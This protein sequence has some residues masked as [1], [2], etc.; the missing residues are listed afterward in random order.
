[1]ENETVQFQNHT[2]F[3]G[4]LVRE[5]GKFLLIVFLLAGCSTAPHVSGNPGSGTET[6]LAA[7]PGQAQPAITASNGPFTLTLFS[8]AD[9]TVLSKSPVEIR[10]QVSEDAVLTI[11]QTAFV[12]TAG[13][14]TKTIPLDTGLNSVQIVASDMDGNEVD[15]VLT[16]TYQP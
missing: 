13:T 6:T 12:L 7:N 1:M 14:F 3:Q 8:P 11:N 4:G 9:Q 5:I 10:G 15:L 16:L 2:T